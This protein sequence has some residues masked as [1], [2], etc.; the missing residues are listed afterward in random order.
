MRGG[1]ASYE[2]RVVVRAAV[3]WLPV[4]LGFAVL[5]AMATLTPLESA[6]RPSFVMIVGIVAT[7]LG[8]LWLQAG[9]QREHVLAGN[10]GVSNARLAISSL[11][12]VIALEILFG[13]VVR[14]LA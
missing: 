10:L 9:R 13:Y 4:R 6:V 5:Y 8:L 1:W 2:T 14:E 3:F 11:A 12:T 7:T